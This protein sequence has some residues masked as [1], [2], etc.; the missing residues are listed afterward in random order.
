MNY[1]AWFDHAKYFSWDGKILEDGLKYKSAQYFHINVKLM[2]LN[3][4]LGKFGPSYKVWLLS[5]SKTSIL[6]EGPQH[7]MDT[8]SETINYHNRGSENEHYVNLRQNQMSIVWLAIE[9]IWK[10]HV[11]MRWMQRNLL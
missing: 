4:T 3:L 9:K 1:K 10:R 5:S 6:C 8:R 11:R 7:N 2:M